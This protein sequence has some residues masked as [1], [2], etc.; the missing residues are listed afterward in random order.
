MDLS[1]RGA[2]LVAVL[3]LVSSIAIPV[4]AEI[5]DSDNRPEQ[6]P[7]DGSSVPQIQTANNS[8]KHHDDPNAVSEGGDISEV[9]GWL[10]DRLANRLGDSA[11]QISQG[12]Y[13]QAQSIIGDDYDSRLEQLIDV[14]GETEG[15]SDDEAADRLS[16]IQRAQRNYSAAASEYNETYR[17]YQEAREA[18]NETAA[19][20]Y[21]RELR[22][23]EQD[24]E[25]LNR[26]L[27]RNYEQVENLT[28]ADLSTVTR[29]IGSTTENITTQQRQL[30]GELFTPTRLQIRADSATVAYDDP[31]T[32]RGQLT[33][34][35]GSALADRS[36][37][38]RI[39]TQTQ[40]VETDADGRFTLRYRPRTLP[41]NT[42]M[43]RVEY[44]PEA[45][46]AFLPANSTVAVTVEQVEATIELRATPKRIGYDDQVEVAARL[47]HNGE[48]VSGIPLT[49]DINGYEL[50]NARTT[51]DGNAAMTGRLP[52]TIPT[53]KY[54]STVS[55][56]VAGRAVTADPATTPL[57]VTETAT[58]LSIAGE[59]V[60]ETMTLSGRLTTTDGDPLD[61]RTV[62]LTIPEGGDHTV[63]TGGNGTYSVTLSGSELSD[64]VNGSLAVTA[65]FDGGGTN[66]G[67]VSTSER[68]Q[69]ETFGSTATQPS[70]GLPLG[71]VAVVVVCLVLAG[72]GAGVVRYS[73]SDDDDERPPDGADYI[74]ESDIET[75][76]AAQDQPDF[77]TSWS[78]LEADR[79]DT[80]VRYTY[81]QLREHLTSEVSVRHSD[82]HWEFLAKC[83]RS[84]L[85]ED[86]TVV[87]EELV[88]TYERS[89]FYGDG[90]DQ[91]IDSLMD[92][93]ES[94]WS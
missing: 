61:D 44:V 37:T 78:L 22:E 5:S 88:Q 4:S 58:T 81:Q 17:E 48:P 54:Q 2:A 56:A 39:H 23:I 70:G 68:I 12:Q 35:N 36:I 73:R 46:S 65:R 25:Q 1:T 30:E 20:R 57:T 7:N 6:N 59:R 41:A 43:L 77:S 3:L 11:V 62:R 26:T 86:Q 93:I 45:E 29:S 89:R 14:A 94:T 32:I 79:P 71:P 13:E 74:S 55:I 60:G 40:E 38:L 27:I 69:F 90:R 85:P 53:G 52:S 15:D 49:A 33:R 51:A 31:L 92:R 63:Q 21:A 28:G 72:L 80:A 84:G 66:L 10:T 82:T 64:G 50:P 91:D 9:E 83:R 67:S 75:P 42:S 16:I 24:V 76:D 18:S 34:E 87:L 19:R 8:T 47:V